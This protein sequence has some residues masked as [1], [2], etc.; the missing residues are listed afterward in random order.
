MPMNYLI[1]PVQQSG[2]P[3]VPITESTGAQLQGTEGFSLGAGNIL[4]SSASGTVI[5]QPA[6]F[7]DNVV[8]SGNLTVQ[9]QTIIQTGFLSGTTTQGIVIN[10]NVF[11]TAATASGQAWAVAISGAA[12]VSAGTQAQSGGNVGNPVG[13]FFINVAQM[14]G[15]PWFKVP[16]Y[17]S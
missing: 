14:S 17:N 16:F 2:S 12:S 15:A 5:A 7:T 8:L 11:G 10:G 3:N 4:G 1:A 6:I 13:F 9:N